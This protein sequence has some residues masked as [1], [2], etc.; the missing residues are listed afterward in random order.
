M[1]LSFFFHP[2]SGETKRS[3]CHCRNSF[4]LKVFPLPLFLATVAGQSASSA[5]G[6]ALIHIVS[7]IVVAGNG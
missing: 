5:D 3:A 6:S 7:A 4:N 1:L 2:L